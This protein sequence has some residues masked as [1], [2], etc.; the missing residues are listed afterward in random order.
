MP[1]PVAPPSPPPP[2]PLDLA[3][4]GTTTVTDATALQQAIDATPPG[5]AAQLFA[6]PG[7]RILLDGTALNISDSKMISLVSSG[8]GATIDGGGRSRLFTLL[9]GAALGVAGVNCTNGRATGP[10]SDP[11]LSS[12]ANGGAFFASG[13]SNLTLVGAFVIN[14]T[15]TGPDGSEQ[16]G[17]AI[18]LQTQ[19]VA[20]LDTCTFVGCTADGNQPFGGAIFMCNQSVAT[21]DTCAF[22]GCSVNAGA[23]L[24]AVRAAPASWLA[25]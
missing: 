24:D 13:S 9:S 20:T 14:C 11:P 2:P 3:P 1:S 4:A 8:E 22:V 15:V 10:F 6:P 5:G 25:S 21:L 16:G 12:G 19:S 17:G 7:T 18:Y 23:T